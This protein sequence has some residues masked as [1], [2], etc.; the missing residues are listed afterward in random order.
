MKPAGFECIVNNGSQGDQKS[1]L[2]HASKKEEGLVVQVTSVSEK[3]GH[4][5]VSVV[6][7]KGKAQKVEKTPE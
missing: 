1:N 5:T 3:E 7:A 6:A 4:T 2:V